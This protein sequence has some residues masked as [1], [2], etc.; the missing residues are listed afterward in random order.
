MLQRLVVRAAATSGARDL[1]FHHR[2]RRVASPGAGLLTAAADAARFTTTFDRLRAAAAAA[3]RTL[4]TPR[5][6]A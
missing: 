1:G 5:R 6:M 3:D 4:P 2:C